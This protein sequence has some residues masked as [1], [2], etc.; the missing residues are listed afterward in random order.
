VKKRFPPWSSKFQEKKPT[1]AGC[2]PGIATLTVPQT[3]QRRRLPT[4]RS[5]NG[6]TAASSRIVSIRTSLSY[7]MQMLARRNKR[8]ATLSPR[9]LSKRQ[10]PTMPAAMVELT[11]QLN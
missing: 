5:S 10:C 4:D 2:R 7:Q 11:S 3:V 6:C 1:D 8:S 9:Y